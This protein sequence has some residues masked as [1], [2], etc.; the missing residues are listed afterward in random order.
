MEAQGTLLAGPLQFG[1]SESVRIVW[2]A[3]FDQS[4]E[5]PSQL[6]GRSGDGGLGAKF[7]LNRKLQVTGQSFR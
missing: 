6:V 7:G 1:I 2:A 3:V 5:N 4:V